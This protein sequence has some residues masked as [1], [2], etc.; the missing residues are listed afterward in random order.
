MV[1]LLH[2]SPLVSFPPGDNTGRD[3]SWC[4]STHT[5]TYTHVHMHVPRP[6]YV[7]HFEVCSSLDQPGGTDERYGAGRVQLRK[8]KA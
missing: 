4:T 5:H 7:Y 6:S 2:Q 8:L 1:L 3:D